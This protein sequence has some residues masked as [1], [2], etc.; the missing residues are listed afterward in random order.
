MFTV[1]IGCFLLP[2]I[3]GLGHL[4]SLI[5]HLV[6]CW[7][8]RLSSSHLEHSGGADANP[9]PKLQ[10]W[11]RVLGLNNQGAPPLRLVHTWTHDPRQVNT[12][13]RALANATTVTAML[14]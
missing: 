5:S 13:H 7:R 2:S 9:T 4:C 8:V 11:A 12:T 1:N 14:S 10:E 3:L 6:F